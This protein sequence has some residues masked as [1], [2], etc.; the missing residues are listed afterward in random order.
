[1]HRVA[2]HDRAGMMTGDGAGVIV[3]LGLNEQRVA[4]CGPFRPLRRVPASLEPG[5]FARG[6]RLSSLDRARAGPPQLLG[7]ENSVVTQVS[8]NH[9]LIVGT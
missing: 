9:V 7:V 1:M 2:E 3:E 8:R 5:E 6:Q 4:V